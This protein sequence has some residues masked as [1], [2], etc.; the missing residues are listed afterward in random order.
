M[1]GLGL[2]TSSDTRLTDGG[3]VVDFRGGS[4]WWSPATGAHD[5]RG[6]IN[7]KY[8]ATGGPS[9]M[10]YPTGNDSPDRVPGVWYSNFQQGDIVWSAGTGAQ[11]V[12]GPILQKWISLGASGGVLGLPTTS[13]TRLADGSYQVTFQ[14]GV[15]SWTASGGPTV[16][17][18]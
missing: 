17:L 4:V 3:Y 7:A 10:G 5:V 1:G 18:G 11:V 14:H 13:D 2:P 6:A 8:K 12:R 9:Y 15:I 16:R